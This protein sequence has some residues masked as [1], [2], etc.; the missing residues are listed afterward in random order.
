[1]QT[2]FLAFF[3]SG[4]AFEVT[5]FFQNG[6]IGFA[7]AD[8]QC[9]SNAVTDCTRLTGHAAAVNVD[10]DVEFVG[11]GNC[12]ERLVDDESH[13]VKRE[14]ILECSL[15]DGDVA[16]TGDKTDSCDGSLSSAGAAVLNFLFD[17][18]LSSHNSPQLFKLE[19][20]GALSLMIVLAADINAELLQ[21][22]LA[23][24][25]LGEHA[26]DSFVNGKFGF[27]VHQFLVLDFFETADEAG[28]IT[29]I[30]LFEFLAGEN[31]LFAVDNTDMVTT[32]DVVCHWTRE[33][34]SPF[35]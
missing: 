5:R 1:M 19:S 21:H 6:T 24:G 22:L 8:A 11:C 9:S 17:G 28:V 2:V 23:E 30:F 25:V 18:F 14:V 27:L 35:A 20:D 15:V 3:L 32:V 29:V 7:V 10:D 16:F 4:V 12:F 31:H 33:S 26:L 34:S 13:R